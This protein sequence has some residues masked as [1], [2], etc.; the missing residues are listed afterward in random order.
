[1][2]GGAPIRRLIA[3]ILLAAAL[4]GCQVFHAYRGVDVQILDAE[5]K[6]PI[7]GADVKISYPLETSWLAP[8][9]SKGITTGDG[10]AHLS[11][12]PFGRAG[13]MIEASAKGYMGEVKYLSPEEIEALKPALGQDTERRAD[14]VIEVFADPKPTVLLVV[15]AGF[16]GVIKADVK[17][18]AD[19]AYQAWQRLFRYDVPITGEVVVTGPAMFRHVTAANLRVQFADDRPIAL[20]AKDA[21]L[22]YWYLKAEGKCFYFFVGTPAGFDS[23]CLKTPTPDAKN[24]PDGKSGRNRKTSWGEGGP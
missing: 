18:Q 2:P 17:V 14:Y 13:I 1:M 9:E 6:Q 21:S 4:P 23:Y 12:T 10:I 8:S 11:A 16:R 24:P 7:T 15:P 22:G 19:L 3:M 5:T 20:R